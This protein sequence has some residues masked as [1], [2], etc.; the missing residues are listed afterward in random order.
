M[1]WIG[2]ASVAFW[3]LVIGILVLLGGLT[4]VGGFDPFATAWLTAVIAAMIVGLIIYMLAVR[5]ALR[6]HTNADLARQVHSMRE[7]RGF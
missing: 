7:R 5:H 2:S 6:D 1:R 3:T 4:I